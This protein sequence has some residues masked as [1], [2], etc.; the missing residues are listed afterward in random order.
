MPKIMKTTEINE[1]SR[2]RFNSV[3]L[4]AIGF[5]ICSIATMP[6]EFISYGNI[7]VAIASVVIA[8]TGASIVMVGFLGIIKV[9]R[10]LKSD[11]KLREI[12]CDETYKA[13]NYKFYTW[14]SWVMMSVV[15]AFQIISTFT[16]TLPVGFVCQFTLLAGL[17]TYFISYLILQKETKDERN[18]AE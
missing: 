11:S 1:I 3:R 10:T 18:S 17:S 8:L 13:N 15:I 14:G 12:L 16:T 5:I 2:K 9:A 7:L 6:R 4:L